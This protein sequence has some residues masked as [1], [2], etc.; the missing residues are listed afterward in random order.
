MALDFALAHAL[1]HDGWCPAGRRAEDGPLPPQYQLRETTSRRYDQRTRWNV[2]D[3]DGTV[4]FAGA[5]PL[6]GGTRLTSEIAVKQSKPLLILCR[7]ETSPGDA[8]ERLAR[9]VEGHAIVRLNVAGPRASQAD[10]LELFVDD[11]LA[12]WFRMLTS[13]DGLPD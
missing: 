4:I 8:A 6:Q 7:N 11:V 2:R 5:R 13:S 3:S 1:P 10:A 9:F 12:R